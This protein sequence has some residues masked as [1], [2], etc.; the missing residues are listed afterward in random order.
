MCGNCDSNRGGGRW[1]STL[2]SPDFR[3]GSLRAGARPFDSHEK[4]AVR[5]CGA[6]DHFGGGG[7]RTHVREALAL[8]IY[9]RSLVFLDL[10]PR[11]ADG[12]AFRADQTEVVALRYRH[13][14]GAEPAKWGLEG[15]RALPS[16][17]GPRL[18]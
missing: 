7:N 3:A 17:P 10:V 8:G 9:A 11:T 16:Q 18:S 14:G 15:P 6:N 12:Q 1:E 4:M 2:R 5:P 13:S